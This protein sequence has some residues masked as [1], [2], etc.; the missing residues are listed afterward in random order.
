MARREDA[1]V[2]EAEFRSYYGQPVIKAPVWHV[3][4]MPLYLYLGGLSGGASLM[5]AAARLAG[6]DRL[7]LTA[8][9]TAAAGATLGAGF[10]VADDEGVG[11]RR[12]GCRTGRC[13]TPVR[14]P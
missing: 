13:R 2:P 7:G 11:P 12:W 10:L 1:M 8:R 14:A 9:V 5:S 4:H 6:H 3:P